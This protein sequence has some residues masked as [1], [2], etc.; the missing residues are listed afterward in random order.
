MTL[1]R[2]HAMQDEWKSSLGE[3]ARPQRRTGNRSCTSSAP[4][5]ASRSRSPTGP[6]SS[7]PT[8]ISTSCRSCSTTTATRTAARWSETPGSTT[9]QTILY[10]FGV[11]HEI[12]DDLVIDVKS[13]AKDISKQVGYHDGLRDAGPPRRPLRQQVVR[14][15]ART[16]VRADEGLHRYFSAKR[17]VY[18][19]VGDRLYLVGVRRLYPLP[20]QSSRTRSASGRSTGTSGTSSSSRGRSPFL[21]TFILRS[22]G[23]SCPTTGT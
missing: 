19:P 12:L 11:T 8:A 18:A 6:S 9:E 2:Q 14:P 17:D 1:P 21:P 23:S 13:Y 5:S 4:A 10:E 3:G 16:R 15:R 20:E 7:S 22:S